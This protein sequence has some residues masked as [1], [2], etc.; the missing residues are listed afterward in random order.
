MKTKMN[1][2]S[3]RTLSKGGK[4]WLDY[5]I[6]DGDRYRFSTDLTD[7]KMNKLMVQRKK[8]YLASEHYEQTIA[9]DVMAYIV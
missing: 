3:V 4:I 7:S 8:V 5:C 6:S 2:R 1:I 9:Y